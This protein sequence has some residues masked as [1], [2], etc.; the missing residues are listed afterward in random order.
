MVQRAW[1]QR[2]AVEHELLEAARTNG[3]VTEDGGPGQALATI[4]SGLDAG[5]NHPHPDLP[6]QPG[7]G[8]V[9]QASGG[10]GS[11][12]GATAVREPADAEGVSLDDFR[13]YMPSHAYIFVPSREMWP[14]TSVNARIPPVP[15]MDKTGKPKLDGNG[16]I[17]VEKASSWLDQHRAVEQMT[18]APGEPELIE[19]RLVSEGGWIERSG[20]ATFNLYRPPTIILGGADQAEKWLDHV[21]RVYTEDAA[22]ILSWLAHRVQRPHEKINHALVL[23]GAQGIG[24]DTIL[25]PVKQAIGPWNFVEVSPQQLLGRFNGFVKAVIL[26]VSEARD[27]GEVDRFAFYDHMK[28]YTA[29]PPDVLRVDEKHLREYAVLNVCGVIITTN[30]KTDGVYLPIDDRRHYVTWSEL[31]KEAFSD[32]YWR[33]IY[34]WYANGGTRHVAAYLAELDISGFDPKA[35]PPKTRA[36]WDIV[37][38]SRAPEDDQLADALDGLGNPAATTLEEISNFAVADLCMWLRDRRNSRQIPHRMETVGYVAVRN[39]ADK[40][41]GR[42]KVGNKRQVVYA[43]AELPVADRFRAAAAFVASRR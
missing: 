22:H 39:P 20:V 18:W 2:D 13:A 38:S 23:G 1:L 42:W 29:A 7:G 5:M 4:R 12:E 36:F 8:R 28:V 30:H 40:S 32:G 3:L 17:V 37:D 15:V 33:E 41:D 16:K 26:R 27:L 9:D 6:D 31:T 11:D 21:R 25:E 14:A 34:T 24:K 19:D 35:P 10:N 43:K